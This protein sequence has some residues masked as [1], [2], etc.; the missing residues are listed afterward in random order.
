MENKIKT[1]DEYIVE[2]EIN[3]LIK[4]HI[5]M[6]IEILEIMKYE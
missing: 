4:K 1:L 5:D 3:S 6:Y 2:E